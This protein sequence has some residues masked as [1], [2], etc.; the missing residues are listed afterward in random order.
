MRLGGLI[1]ALTSAPHHVHAVREARDAARIHGGD[2]RGLDATPGDLAPEA[3]GNATSNLAGAERFVGLSKRVQ[4]SVADQ[5]HA[6]R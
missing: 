5:T 6:G 3:C 4:D 1:A 2:E